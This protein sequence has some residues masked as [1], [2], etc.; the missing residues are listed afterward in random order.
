MN[1]EPEI[2]TVNDVLKAGKTLKDM[3]AEE[4]LLVRANTFA[5]SDAVRD[6]VEAE[7][8]RRLEGRAV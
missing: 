2:K 4:L 6:S 1:T 5:E 7:V 8:I 3:S